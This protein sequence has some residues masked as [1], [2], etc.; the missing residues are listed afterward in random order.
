M[1]SSSSQ[2]IISRGRSRGGGAA[3]GVA[4]VVGFGAKSLAV[5]PGT[6]ASMMRA[7]TSRYGSG[8]AA[9]ERQNQN[10]RRASLSNK[11][12]A[13]RRRSKK[14][15]REDMIHGIDNHWRGGGNEREMI[16]RARILSR[17]DG[18][19]VEASFDLKSG[20]N[21]ISAN[22]ALLGYT[23]GTYEQRCLVCAVG[24]DDLKVFKVSIPEGDD[25]QG[26]VEVVNMRN[27]AKKKGLN[28]STVDVKWSPTTP[29]LVATAATNGAV[30]MW[31]LDAS[32]S[33][34]SAPRNRQLNLQESIYK[35]HTRSVNR[36]AWHPSE[37]NLLV[38]GS[39]DGTIK[40]WDRRQAESIL[41]LKPNS[42]S[43]RDVQYCPTSQSRLAASFDNGTVQVWDVRKVK[44]REA[45]LSGHNGIVLAIDWHPKRPNILASGGRDRWI[46]VWDLA[47][48]AAPLAGSRSRARHAPARSIQTIASV[49][50][51]S[52]RPGYKYQLASSA[53][54][55]D[56]TVQV[57]S[58]LRP[59]APLACVRG[60]NNVTTGVLW[61]NQHPGAS[62]H[63]FEER[64]GVRSK[65]AAKGILT[66]L[67]EAR[68]FDHPSRS[69]RS[70]SSSAAS[71]KRFN[72]DVDAISRHAQYAATLGSAFD[73]MAVPPNQPRRHTSDDIYGPADGRESYSPWSWLI[74]CSKDG[75]IN[76][77]DVNL[78]HR[79]L[80][81]A[82]G[83]GISLSVGDRIAAHHDD[84]QRSHHVLSESFSKQGSAD[85]HLPSKGK[86]IS[87]A[88]HEEGESLPIMLPTSS[89]FALYPGAQS[90]R[91]ARLAS[92][93]KIRPDSSAP[94]D[95]AA[96]CMHNAKMAADVGAH[97]VAQV[98]RIA[99]MIAVPFELTND[100]LT[101]ALLDS[102]D[103]IVDPYAPID[104]DPTSQMQSSTPLAH[105]RSRAP[106]VATPRF[107]DKPA[108]AELGDD[109]GDEKLLMSMVLDR[110]DNYAIT[111]PPFATPVSPSSAQA[112]GDL[113]TAGAK[114]ARP[115]VWSDKSSAGHGLWQG[116][117]I[118]L[119][120]ELEHANPLTRDDFEMDASFTNEG[121]QE[122]AVALQN[123]LN[124]QGKGGRNGDVSADSSL[125]RSSSVIWTNF[126]AAELPGA[127]KSL[128]L[129]N[130]VFD[131]QGLL[132]NVLVHHADT[133]DV[134]TCATICCVLTDIPEIKGISDALKR[135]WFTY[136]VELLQQMQLYDLAATVI[137]ACPDEGVRQINQLS[138]T[139]YSLC[140]S[141]KKSLTK[142]GAV[143]KTCK[144]AVS[145][146]SVCEE[147][148]RGMYVW[149]DVCG[150]G[151]HLHHIMSWFS[152]KGRVCP[153]RGCSHKCSF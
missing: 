85:R 23:Q 141:C 153:V 25:D 41:T 15:S 72:T 47:S 43:V 20:V 73:G 11:T 142:K 64:R 34:P 75:S 105:P 84:I 86:C 119:L 101:D 108:I 21:A 28:L 40:M 29:N 46:H 27:H 116:S 6:G 92:R 38:S 7:A 63:S 107:V 106:T 132:Q 110:D 139:I 128:F 31:N 78:A 65:V 152:E 62:R 143:C 103:D 33:A 51:V 134:Q 68:I 37:N 136:Y 8:P 49:S 90:S 26:F 140:R 147:P 114:T 126:D 146:C 112:S 61:T 71:H 22:G 94:S 151:G 144:G 77:C 14:G 35:E 89:P 69:S 30:I 122:L 120:Q 16:R 45:K 54:V 57:W 19:R 66:S 91:F 100:E 70:G 109:F 135:Q 145:R 80:D 124:V 32:L 59:Y 88:Q 5:M 118:H 48:P 52:W 39:Q 60:H 96:C 76:L 148:V 111:P 102:T 17:P 87:I 83:V 4:S 117:S 115:G 53:S 129:D 9:E 3:G 58:T 74:T 131:K 133:G 12:D 81:R 79:P 123:G 93:Y 137:S 50:R 82:S 24:R 138:T 1:S 149:C 44:K 56:N 10:F 130:G 125:R 97:T 95:I 42:E 18:S 98:W 127:A 121:I 55:L 113:I 67:S 36:V 99:R 150:H 2:G 104:A 13:P